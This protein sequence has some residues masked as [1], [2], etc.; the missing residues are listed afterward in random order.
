MNNKVTCYNTVLLVLFCALLCLNLSSCSND[1]DE[2]ALKSFY[3]VWAVIGDPD[4]Y[5]ML[6]TKDCIVFEDSRKGPAVLLPYINASYETLEKAFAPNDEFA[7]YRYNKENDYYILYSGMEE[8]ENGNILFDT[9]NLLVMSIGY[10]GENMQVGY[11]WLDV[12]DGGLVSRKDILT[13]DKYAKIPDN[14]KM[15]QTELTTYFR[16]K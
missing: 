8:D 12:E 13:N 5:P 2:D 6:I 4:S 1:K 14:A 10:A 15:E 11:Q 3:G 7:L 16:V 9:Q